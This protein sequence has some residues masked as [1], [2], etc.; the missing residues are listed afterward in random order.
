[1]EELRTRPVTLLKPRQI[2]ARG[3]HE[4]EGVTQS[5]IALQAIIFLARREP[6]T[7]ETRTALRDLIRKFNFRFSLDY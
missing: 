5:E 7:V 3:T 1:M 2:T 6:Q 4:H